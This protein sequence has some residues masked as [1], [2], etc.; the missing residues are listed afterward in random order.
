MLESDHEIYVAAVASASLMVF[1]AGVVGYAI[2]KYQRRM[3]LH[4][5]E[6]S[7][8]KAAYE[9]E[10]LRSQLEIQEQTMQTVAQEIHD[11]VGQLLS[12]IKINLGTLPPTDDPQAV[13]KLVNTS[14]YL[15]R[16]I[17]DLRGLSKALS[18]EHRLRAGLVAAL[19]AELDAIRD[20]GVVETALTQIGDETRPD[21]RHELI[22]FRIAQEMINNALKHARAKNIRVSLDYSVGRLNLT[23]ADDGVG[24]DTGR[25]IAQSGGGSG[26][27]NIQT[28]AKLIGADVTIRSAVGRGTTTVLSL[29]IPPS[30]S[31]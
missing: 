9:K 26:L 5:Q 24:F 2:F 31:E 29:P 13:E 21:P 22:L 7:R 16:A 1:L 14:A 18:G 19:R 11:N 4:F 6:I 8:M 15:N 27:P 10:L 25:V 12:L 17:G 23:I 30:Q 20:T 3:Q 28:R